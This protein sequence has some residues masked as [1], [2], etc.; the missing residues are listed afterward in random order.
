MS[1]HP[2][3]APATAD[4]ATTTS[5]TGPR[6]PVDEVPPLRRLLPLGLQHVLAMYAGA[7]AVPLVIGTALIEA[8]RLDPGALPHLITAD[9]FVAGIGAVLQSVGVWRVGAR[10]PLMQGCTFASVG[11]MITIGT[12]HGV[13]AIYGS[14]IMCGLMMFAIA[15]V[16]SQL[17]RFFP[18]LVTGT[19]ILVIGLSLMSVAGGWVIDGAT[20]GA[21]PVN[22][23]L[24]A[25]TLAVIVLI[26]RFA[27]PAL[28]RLSILLGLVVGTLAAVPL[29]L[30]D[31]SGVGEQPWVGFSTP[32]QFGLPTFPAAA[33][34]SMLIVGLVIMTETTGDIVA[35]SEIVDRPL[36]PRRL[37]D[38][39]RA[40]GLTTVLGG[41][42]NTFPYTAF[43][44]NV[45]LVSI[46]G[47]KSRWVATCAGVMLIALGLVPKLGAVVEAVPLAVLGGAGVALFGIVAASGVRTLSTVRFTDRNVL[48]VALAVGVGL[49]PTVSPT[50][51]ERFPSWFT[52]VFDS[53][54]SAG[55]VVAIALNL[56]LGGERVARGGDSLAEGPSAHDAVRG[57]QLAADP[58]PPTR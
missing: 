51:Y 5:A 19:V 24:A 52:L 3:S 14:V 35:V 46:T 57:A 22:V 49:L 43:A 45:G 40:D 33:V 37:A 7:V 32:F 48:V 23:A 15:P 10:L 1:D 34:I 38:G 44:Q 25:G 55:A 41:V 47:V 29:G 16:F 8:G 26:E 27:P 31:V 36:T 42:F 2:R 28:G 53:G 56:L 39:L 12:E 50:I 6:H 11:P 4:G 54:I 13:G 20:D 30:V 58:E 17:V 21:P 9:L 18:P